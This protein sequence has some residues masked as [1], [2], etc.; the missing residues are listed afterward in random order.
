MKFSVNF[1]CKTD[2]RQKQLQTASY[3]KAVSQYLQINLDLY[4]T[5]EN[6]VCNAENLPQKNAVN[7]RTENCQYL[8]FATKQIAVTASEREI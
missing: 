3:V 5:L 6:Y 4:F 2:P 8:I 7:E 1:V